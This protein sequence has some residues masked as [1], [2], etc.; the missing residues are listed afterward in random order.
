MT[1]I[2]PEI[3]KWARE[4]ARLRL[5]EAAKKLS[6]KEARLEELEAGKRQPTHPQLVKMSQQY[7]RP[8]LTFYIS[9]PPQKADQGQDFRTLPEG[10]TGK[11]EALVDA[12]VRN[13]QTRQSIV[14]S[15]LEEE[16]EAEELSF[17]K[18][19][20][21][22]EHHKDVAD[23]ITRKI[24]FDLKRYQNKSLED[25]VTYLR[26][27]AETAHVFVLMIDN[28]GNYHTKVP[29]KSFRGFALADHIAPFIAVNVN[30]SK[31]A[32]A[33]TILHELTHLW[34]G[35]TGISGPPSS[36]I[37]IEKFCND[38][39]S[40]ILLP[41]DE[42]TPF[43]RQFKVHGLKTDVEYIKEFANERNVSSTMLAYRLHRAGLY[44]YDY[45]LKLTSEFWRVF[46][47]K[48]APK[49]QGFSPYPIVR[50]HRAGPAL[51][52]L[53]S[54]MLRG[55]AITTT[56]AGLVLGVSGKNV[57]SVIESR[58]QQVPA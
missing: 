10:Q 2:N 42:F 32:Q 50:R 30:D 54:R 15:L 47:D 4:T 3:L 27:R 16:D 7:H 45:Y 57:Q 24:E 46:S 11:D 9:N 33:F 22:D 1:E 5:E 26:A 55:G 20:T 25:A 36:K 37:D 14:K 17:I 31:A 56:K 23:K 41:R 28:L 51:V 38:V 48:K 29:V 52:S 18:S 39:A 6:L 8:L 13:I 21:V 53:V 19:A 40:E 43:M 58:R 12:I 34:L 35:Q 49:S 44:D